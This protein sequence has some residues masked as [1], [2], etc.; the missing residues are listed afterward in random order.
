MGQVVFT[1]P[2]KGW[3]VV[4]GYDCE[5]NEFFLYVFDIRPAAQSIT[6]W[7]NLVNFDPEDRLRTLRLRRQLQGM[8]VTAPE[9]FWSR[10]ELKDGDNVRHVWRGGVWTGPFKGT[11]LK[12]LPEELVLP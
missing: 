10:V 8:G 12:P 7:S 4:G 3:E 6:V 5:C 11:L 9:G 2:E 1:V